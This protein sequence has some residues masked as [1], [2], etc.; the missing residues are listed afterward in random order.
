MPISVNGNPINNTDPVTPINHSTLPLEETFTDTHRFGEYHPHLVIEGIA[1]DNQP[2]RC[3]HK[4]RSYTLKAPLMQDI[5]LHKDYF[6]VTQRAV[7]PFQAERVQKNPKIGDDVPKDAYTS[8]ENFLSKVNTFAG[9]IHSIFTNSNASFADRFTAYMKY[10]IFLECIYSRGSL[11][12]S[13]GCNLT[14]C[15]MVADTN[16]DTEMDFDDYFDV[17]VKVSSRFFHLVC[18]SPLTV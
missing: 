5:Q 11:L 8:V 4:A 7:L 6:M 18:P 12:A 13:L 14:S 2:W 3:V 1:G 17:F 10:L 16:L 15:M 9:S